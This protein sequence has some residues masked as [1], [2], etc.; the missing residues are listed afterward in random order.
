MTLRR[1]GLRPAPVVPGSTL[2]ARGAPASLLGAFLAAAA[3]AFGE[4]EAPLV[5]GELERFAQGLDRGT[6][7]AAVVADGELPVS[8]SSLIGPGPVAELAGVWTRPPWRRR[9]YARAVCGLLLERYRRRRGAGLAVGG[10]PRER[11]ALSPPGLRAVRR[12]AQ[13]CRTRVRRLTPRSPLTTIPNT[14]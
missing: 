1:G 5:A 3:E 7:A 2:L 8:G 10:R 9:G 4:P 11:R 12:A 6:L 14:W 13:L